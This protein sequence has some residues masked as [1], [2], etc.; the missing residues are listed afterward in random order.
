ME[1]SFDKLYF[2]SPFFIIKS[3]ALPLTDINNA[4]MFLFC[5]FVALNVCFLV[6]LSG[7]DIVH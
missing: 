5:C 1:W 2:L 3:G 7:S 6:L 4:L